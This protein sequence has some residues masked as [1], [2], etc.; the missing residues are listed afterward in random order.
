MKNILVLTDFSH[1]AYEALFYITGLMKRQEADFHILNA[2][3]E[4]T[5]LNSPSVGNP[6][7][8]LVQQLKDEA[9]EGLQHTVH[10]IQLD[11]DNPG[12]R[13]HMIARNE[14][15]PDAVTHCISKGKIDLI[16]MGNKGQSD[17]FGVFFGSNVLR[18]L[19]TVADLPVLAV[20]EGIGFNKPNEIAFAA[21]YNR[22]Y[23]QA[24]LAPLVEITTLCSAA[25]RV[26]HLNE[27]RKLTQAQ[28]NNVEVLKQVLGTTPHTLHWM[29]DFRKK[30]DALHSFITEA[31]I[32]MLAMVHYRHGFLDRLMREDVI[33]KISFVIEVPFLVLP[34]TY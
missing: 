14:F 27:E 19:K 16:V 31:G 2:F 13:F 17:R 30:A 33:Q 23:N 11:R 15:L 29:P 6:P 21:D 12:H 28:L 18:I 8:P 9:M 24:L 22:P 34:D 3:T 4:H 10:R 1:T 25:I 7:K 32:G 5:P 26:V 20:P